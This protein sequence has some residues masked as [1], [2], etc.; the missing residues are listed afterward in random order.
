[1]NHK[2]GDARSDV[3]ALGIILYEMLTGQTPFQGPNPLAVM[4]DRVRNNPIPPREVEPTISPAMQE[5]IYRALERDPKN[6]YASAREMAWDLEHQD[7]VGV[8]ERSELQDWRWHRTPLMKRILLYSGLAAIP[9]AIF[10]LLMLVAKN[11]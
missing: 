7:R 4:N 2:R 8:T 6:R 10:S 3:Y 5:I 1:M 9:A 11:A